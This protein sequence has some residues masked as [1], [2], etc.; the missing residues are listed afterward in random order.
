MELIDRD[1]FSF[2]VAQ[3]F[4]DNPNNINYHLRLF[5]SRVALSSTLISLEYKWEGE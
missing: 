5:T 4:Y 3:Q 1:Y 2:L